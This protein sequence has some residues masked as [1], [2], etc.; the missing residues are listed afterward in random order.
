MI[1]RKLDMLGLSET[2][3]KGQGCKELRDGFYLYWSGNINTGR[4]GVGIIVNNKI[5]MNVVECQYISER[6]LTLKIKIHKNQV[7]DIL[8]CY[9]PQVGCDDTEKLQFEELL[10]EN[11]RSDNVIIIGD[12]NAQVGQDR[13]NCESIIGAHGWGSRNTEGKRLIDLCRRNNLA[14]GNTWYKKRKSH[15]ITRY[16]WD[17]RY[18]TVIDYTILSKEIHNTLCDTKVIPNVSLGS[19]HRLL[20]S[21]FK[22]R[23]LC[24]VKMN[25]ERKIKIWKLKERENVE[26]FQSIIQNN[27]PI[28]ELQSVEEEWKAYKNCLI[29]AAEE[30]CGR[31]SGRR[32]WKETPWWNERVKSAVCEKNNMFRIYFKNRTLEN[33]DKYKRS[34]QNAKTVVI[35]ERNVWLEKWSNTLQ[36]DVDGNKKVLYG[37]V[38]NKRRDREE[39][40]YLTNDDGNL[41]SDNDE[42]KNIWKEYFNE[43]LNVV[44]DNEENENEDI[45]GTNSIEI[46]EDTYELMWNDI[47]YVWKFIKTGKATGIDEISGEMIK[48]SGIAGK[49][50]LYRLFRSIWINKTVPDDWRMGVVVP[51]FKKGDRKKCSNFRGI[52]LTS[53]VSK[54]YERLLENKIRPIIETQLNEE[55][56]GFRAGRSTIDLIFG[57][58]QLMEKKY[59][60]GK[61]LWMA[62]L[63]I[64]K[65]FDAVRRTKVWD[66]LQHAGINKHMVDRIQ[67][68]YQ[69]ISS[70]VR[71]PVGTT[72]SFAITTGLRQGG[73]LSPLLFI[74]VINEIQN[75]V[76]EKIGSGKSNLMLFADDIVLWGSNNR[77]IQIQIDAWAEKAKSY[78]LIFSQEKSEVLI[79]HKDNKPD[80]SV[81]L[82]GKELNKVQQ[83]KYLGSTISEKGTITEEIN[84]RINTSSRFY[85]CIKGIIWNK[86]VPLKCKRT[87]YQTYFVPI[88]TYGSETWTVKRKEESRIQAAEMKFLRSTVGKTRRDRIRNENIRSMV[89]TEKLQNRIEKTRLRWYGH[90]KRMDDNRIAKKMLELKIEG[91]RSKGRP[92]MRYR[93]MISSDMNKRGQDLNDIESNRKYLDRT[94]YRGVVNRPVE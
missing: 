49:H 87:I 12:L 82:D 52:T 1:E 55:Q 9:A 94:W 62:F 11:I 22:F 92:R 14:I 54:L 60:F 28:T 50:W 79:L 83:F 64:K 80:G 71:T 74:N 33:R 30:V 88:L 10:E 89:G 3:W 61:D 67:D 46:Q 65:A 32:R 2:K 5:K 31:T 21:T 72:D 15:K 76:C 69:D 63:D 51:L 19:D 66:A 4:H 25:Q 68:L 86:N 75:K 84:N 20:V 6:L 93:D 73:V 78:G 37:M 24:E 57:L 43:L 7:I 16:S 77:E 81:K 90:V 26:K 42:I 38:K 18:E 53:Q 45:Q 59:E 8:Q 70:K 91:V 41:V 44:H 56:Y 34:K 40:K 27:I 35:E 17:G 48:N 47:D 13:Y 29:H 85:N 58:R 36:N 39:C 23:K